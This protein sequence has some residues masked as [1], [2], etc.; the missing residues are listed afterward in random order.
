MRYA[1]WRA[2]GARAL[3]VVAALSQAD[4]RARYGRGASRMV[5]WLLDP[6][7]IVGVYLALVTIVLDRGGPAP[8]LSLACAVVPFQLLMLTMINSLDSIQSRSAILANMAFPRGLMP[9]ASVVTESI[10]FGA[11]LLLLAGMMAVYGVSPTPAILWFP[12]VL[13]VNLTLACSLAYPATLV[14]LWIRDLRQFAI[15]FVRTTFFLAAGLVALA[16]I[17]G[18]AQDLVQLNPLTGLF[19]AYRSVL[20]YGE[21]PAA[22]ELVYPLGLA[23]ALAAVFVPLFFRERAHL[24]KVL[25]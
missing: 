24:A 22:W 15:S 10:A 21:A 8:G 17:T 12:V 6:F 2:D 11:S 9:I 5:K 4:L 16:E 3:D 14:G 1:S 23:A 18:D 7:A 20:L 13:A 25:D 19:E